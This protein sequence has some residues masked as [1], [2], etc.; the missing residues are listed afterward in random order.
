MSFGAR[1]SSYAAGGGG[2]PPEFQSAQVTS[3]TGAV[4]M[5]VTKPVDTVAGDI[6]IA[7][8]SIRINEAITPPADWD[9][10]VLMT[11]STRS[12]VFVKVAGG[13]EPANY[14]WTWT[15]SC[16]GVAAIARY[17][18]GDTTTPIDVAGTVG[19]AVTNT[20]IAPSVDTTQANCTLLCF[21]TINNNMS[22]T[23]DAAMDERWDQTTTNFSDC[24]HEMADEALS[25][26]GATGTRTATASGS[27][28]WGAVLVALAPA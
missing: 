22:F 25:A 19:T 3:T 23:P 8:V 14:Q 24:A 6:L 15:T 16:K 1:A 13:S 21:L 9:S 11:P 20:P 27:D 5:T 7:Q 18:G 10:V 12:E 4:S 2:T 26:S 28:T 17:T